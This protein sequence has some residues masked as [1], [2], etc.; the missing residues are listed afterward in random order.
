LAQ[1]FEAGETGQAEIEDNQ[2]IGLG[3]GDRRRIGP[4]GLMIDGEAR[5]PQRGREPA[6]QDS[7]ILDN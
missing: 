3:D 6:R 1:H 4:V 2:R 5:E 7:I